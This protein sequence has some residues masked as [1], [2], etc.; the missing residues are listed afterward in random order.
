MK[1][2]NLAPAGHMWEMYLTDPKA[3]PESGQ[4]DHPAVLAG[5]LNLS[6]VR[7]LPGPLHLRTGYFIGSGSGLRG[8]ISSRMAA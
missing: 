5:R 4:V 1:A 8:S 7:S 3:E 6:A 2:R